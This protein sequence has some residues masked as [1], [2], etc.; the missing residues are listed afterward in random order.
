MDE[1]Q[2]TVAILGAVILAS[3]IAIATIRD[4]LWCCGLVDNNNDAWRTWKRVSEI[5]G[6]RLCFG[7]G[8]IAAAASFVLMIFIEGLEDPAILWYLG[9]ELAWSLVTLAGIILNVGNGLWGKQLEFALLV[10]A[11]AAMV[12]V[13]VRNT[14]PYPWIVA[15]QATVFDA[16]IWS[17]L[18]FEC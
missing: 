18:R 13:A 17:H 8:M 3:F 5:P 10:G 6:L 2:E 12:A 15:A 9:F 16:G 4:C 1:F 14:S 11:A 7:I